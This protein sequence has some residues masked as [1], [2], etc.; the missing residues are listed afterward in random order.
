MDRRTL[1]LA[2]L[3][4]VTT[5]SLAAPVSARPP[6]R[7]AAKS[8]PA[9][10]PAPD[11]V[12][13]AVRAFAAMDLGP[14]G[15]ASC[16]IVADERASAEAQG[17]AQEA[18]AKKEDRTLWRAAHAPD[19]ALF[20]GSAVKTFILAGFLQQQEAGRTS[21]SAQAV[22][23]DSVRSLS[24]PVFINL[25]GR[26]PYVSVLEAMITHSDNTA[27]DVALAATGPA[28]V[29]A[30]IQKAGL[31]KTRIPDSTR[32][33][34][35]WLAGGAQGVDPGWQGLQAIAAG[36]APARSRSPVGGDGPTMQSTASDLVNWHR[37]AM[38]GRFFEKPETFLQYRRIM[39]MADALPQ[40]TPPDA[41]AW[42][43]GGSIDWAGFHCFSLAG[44]ML[45]AGGPATFC[46]TINW[47]GPDADTPRVF[48]VYR[49][50]VRKALAE[51]YNARS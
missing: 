13:E 5:A 28:N 32:A 31:T 51:T 41:L 11:P 4:A 37:A 36:P 24:S 39:A 16:L 1:L 19:E 48:A 38:T 18:G 33:L 15:R 22:I 25:T 8:E 9:S 30:L 3:S 46:F 27:T 10:G 45:T 50:A 43:K 34:F 7:Q 29:R 49:D 42:G 14:E 17:G 6:R 2:S 40:V 20:V 44:Q 26:T 35:G 12:N 23:D 47:R 21:M